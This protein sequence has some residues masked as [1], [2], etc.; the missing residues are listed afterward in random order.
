MYVN[1]D[2]SV[3]SFLAK[4][5]DFIHVEVK[6]LHP[7]SE[8]PTFDTLHHDDEKLVLLYKSKKGLAAL[9]QGLINGCIKHFDECIEVTAQ[10]Y[11]NGLRQE[12]KFTLIK[13]ND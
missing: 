13:T 1:E 11:S 3:F 8:L 5:E 12:V 4:L 2:E 10:D 6:K 7:E 9:A